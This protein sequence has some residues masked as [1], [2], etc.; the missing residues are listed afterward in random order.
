MF[1]PDLV[2][3][4]LAIGE[5]RRADQVCEAV[6]A[7]AQVND[8]PSLAG[9]AL[10]CRGLTDDDPGLLAAAAHCYAEGPRL[11][12][13]ALTAEEAGTAHLRHGHTAQGRAL[14]E[15][16]LQTY[17]RLDAARDVLRADA[18][19][20]AAGVHRG[21]AAPAAG[22]RTAGPRSRRRR[23][24]WPTSSLRA[25]LTRR[26]P[27]SCT[28]R[29]APCKRTCH[30]CSPS[31]TSLPGFSWPTRSPGGAARRRPPRADRSAA[32]A[33]QPQPIPRLS[34][35]KDRPAGGCLDVG[36]RRSVG[37]GGDL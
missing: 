19:L 26:S 10:R 35:K 8:V 24:P 30:T 28:S 16:A 29:T 37:A 9:S 21:G 13:A 15:N 17:D 22:P 14:I 25:S 27:G 31:S 2:R 6:A 18:A 11:I 34:D 7:V 32:S 20:R 4:A 33:E 3:L 36:P 12:D 5:R 23:S 1:G